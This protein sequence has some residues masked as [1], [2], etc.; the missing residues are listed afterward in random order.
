MK[1]FGKGWLRRWRGEHAEEAAPRLADESQWST[2]HTAL[3]TSP[4]T[5]AVLGA[6]AGACVGFATRLFLWGLGRSGDVAASITRGAWPIFLLLPVALPL[7]VW[8]IRTFAPDARGHGTE[9]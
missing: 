2:A 7:C 3:L 1:M 4:F 5:W 8:L 6:G 9:A